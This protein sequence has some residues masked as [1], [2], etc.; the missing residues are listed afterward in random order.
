[1]LLFCALFW[2]RRRDLAAYVYI[3]KGAIWFVWITSWLF[4]LAYMASRP[5]ASGFL[6]AVT[7]PV[8]LAK[9][10]L[11]LLGSLIA[12]YL[13][14]LIVVYPFFASLR[15]ALSKEY[16]GIDWQLDIYV[17]DKVAGLVEEVPVSTMLVLHMGLAQV[18]RETKAE[19]QPALLANLWRHYIPLVTGRL[20]VGAAL[21]PPGEP[22]ADH[23]DAN[24]AIRQAALGQKITINKEDAERTRNAAAF[25]LVEGGRTVVVLGADWPR[26]KPFRSTFNLA[27]QQFSIIRSEYI[28]AREVAGDKLTYYGD[29][30]HTEEGGAEET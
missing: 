5:T 21:I 7:C 22:D 9:A 29:P 28:L 10:T 12:V 14:Y 2:R 3:Y 23:P 4:A 18:L 1:M 20:A 30:W 11:W 26:R 19:D 15:P 17:E 13:A 16:L 27:A 6:Q 8:R 24:E 25:P